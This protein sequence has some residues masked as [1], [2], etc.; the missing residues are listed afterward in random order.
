VL[1]ALPEAFFVSGNVASGIF[2]SR[3]VKSRLCNQG[4]GLPKWTGTKNGAR[5]A[6]TSITDLSPP[7]RDQRAKRGNPSLSAPA[8]IKK[9]QMPANSTLAGFF[10]FAHYQKNSKKVILG[11]SNSVSG[12]IEAKNHSLNS[13]NRMKINLYQR[14]TSCPER[15]AILPL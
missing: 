14:Q 1:P 7:S 6:A 2:G 4:A 5:S 11:V 8:L 3:K 9:H 12:K 10:I 15:C 13:H